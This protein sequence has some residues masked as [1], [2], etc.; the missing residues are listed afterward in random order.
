MRRFAKSKPNLCFVNRVTNGRV[1]LAFP[2]AQ[3]SL[4]ASATASQESSARRIRNSE[5]K[6]SSELLIGVALSPIRKGE[7][8][9]RAR[10]DA[11]EAVSRLRKLCISSKTSTLKLG[12]SLGLTFPMKDDEIT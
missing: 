7:D 5:I 8:L 2:A 9:A 4:T 12:Y 1:I 3:Y 6:S 10:A 11:C